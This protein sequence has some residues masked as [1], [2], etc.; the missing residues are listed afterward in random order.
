MGPDWTPRRLPQQL[1][2][3][4][5]LDGGETGT[6]SIVTI[7]TGY[8][9][10]IGNISIDAG[11]ALGLSN[12]V[13]LN[14][15]GN[16]ANAGRL[17]LTG[18]TSVLRV[19][20]DTTFSGGGKVV[21]GGDGNNHIQAMVGQAGNRLINAADHRIEGAG[22]IGGDSM[23]LTNEGQIVANATQPLFID[24]YG[25]ADSFYNR[26]VLRVEP[27]STMIFG[28]NAVQDGASAR[29]E[30][31]GTLNVPLLDLQAGTLT[32]TGTVAGLVQNVGGV[33]APGASPGT[34][35]VGSF[36]QGA[37]GMLAIEL[38][39]L[40]S[41]DL[42]QV[43]GTANLAGTLALSCF[44][45]CRFYVGDEIVILTSGGALSGEFSAVTYSGFLT[46]EFAVLYGAND[47]RLK[48]LVD[49]TPVPEPE[50]WS[51]LLAG[52]GLVGLMARRRRG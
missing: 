29:T 34:L 3:Q 52:L 2:G 14:V 12:N 22:N 7:P 45:D 17:D 19:A 4:C 39:S 9:I 44:G 15:N 24:L 35:S 38:E 40:I 31:F 32:G 41:H 27:T 11:D 6:N 26:G 37:G 30:V 10:D 36:E 16:L 42:L 5:R 18:G 20:N 43:S 49:V 48:V 46:G 21:M 25:D 28:D 51:M 8:V 13:V 33:V 1:R 23:K 47:V 50:T